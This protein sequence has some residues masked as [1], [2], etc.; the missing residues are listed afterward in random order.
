MSV[1]SRGRRG[2]PDKKPVDRHFRETRIHGEKSLFC[3][4]PY[5]FKLFG[6][7]VK[8][9]LP[10]RAGRKIFLSLQKREDLKNLL[11]DFF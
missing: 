11:L 7:E 10:E 6:F 4:L 8:E 5:P 2:G 1:G 9:I 3:I